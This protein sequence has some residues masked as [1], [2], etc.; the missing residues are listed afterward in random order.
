[1]IIH[2]YLPVSIEDFVYLLIERY[3][4]SFPL[5]LSPVQVE[6]IPISEKYLQPAHD[7]YLTLKK[8][9]IR[10]QLDRSSNTVQAKIRNAETDRIPYF[11]I[12]GEKELN[13]NSVSIRQ[14][15]GKELGLVR[16]E[17]FLT[18][19]QLEIPQ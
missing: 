16:I 18:K 6:I 13:T 4:G 1:M 14:R 11:L 2:Y 9:G 10:V 3:E 8:A 12:I 7:V 19:I 5:W 15:D 17:E